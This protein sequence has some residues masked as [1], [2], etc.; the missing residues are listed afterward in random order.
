MKRAGQSNFNYLPF[1]LPFFKLLLP[2][3]TV[4]RIKLTRP[5]NTHSNHLKITCHYFNWALTAFNAEVVHWTSCITCIY[6]LLNYC[7][8]L[9]P[10]ARHTNFSCR[11]V[12][13]S[14]WGKF[15]FRERESVMFYYYAFDVIC[16]EWSLKKNWGGCRK[17]NH[18]CCQQQWQ[19]FEWVLFRKD[20]RIFLTYSFLFIF[21]LLTLEGI[22]GIM[23]NC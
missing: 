22:L 4:D 1:L 21:N 7:A 18:L 16:E 15:Y 8:V 5:Y 10:A 14:V 3:F 9:L 12:V 19:M 11:A 20:E 17:L 13:R 6:L 2:V 23:Q